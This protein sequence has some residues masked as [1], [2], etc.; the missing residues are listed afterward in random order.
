MKENKGKILYTKEEKGRIF[1]TMKEQ[2][3]EYSTLSRK[4]KI[5][6]SHCEGKSRVNRSRQLKSKGLAPSHISQG[7]SDTYFDTFTQ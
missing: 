2:T 7:G 6:P 4:R 3:V 5:I 1:H